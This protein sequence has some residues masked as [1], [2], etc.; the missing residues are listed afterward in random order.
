M[1]STFILAQHR[2]ISSLLQMMEAFYSIDGYAFDNQLTKNNLRLLVDD[3]N[4]GKAFLVQ[5]NQSIVG[6][7]LITYGFSFEYG[8]RTALVDEIYIK[9]EFRHQGLGK[10]IMEYIE[11]QTK[12]EQIKLLQL[13]V[14]PRNTNAEMLYLNYGFTQNKRKILT[15]HLT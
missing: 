10:Q 3:S 15:K 5:A 14:E 9:E 13:E 8:G 6:Y 11:T 12:K 7:F 2:H 1:T 4:L